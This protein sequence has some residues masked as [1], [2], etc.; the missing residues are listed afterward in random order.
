MNNMLE[1]FLRISKQTNNIKFAKT[2]KH[3]AAPWL[4]IFLTFTYN[5]QMAKND[6][7]AVKLRVKSVFLL[8]ILYWN[9]QYAESL[10]PY[11]VL[12]VVEALAGIKTSRVECPFSADVESYPSQALRPWQQPYIERAELL[13]AKLRDKLL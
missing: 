8:F 2:S 1:R 6:S 3:L 5:T 10:V 9:P 12:R 11:C 4:Q 13:L 7:E